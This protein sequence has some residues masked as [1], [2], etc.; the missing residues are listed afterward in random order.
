MKCKRCNR[1]INSKLGPWII[2]D[3]SRY[4]ECPHCENVRE[5]EIIRSKKGKIKSKVRR[6]DKHK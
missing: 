4:Y 5:A 2:N 6:E 3:K 1:K